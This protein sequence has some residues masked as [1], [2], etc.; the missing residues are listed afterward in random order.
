MGDLPTAT[1]G[2]TGLKV[3]RLGFGAMELR[4]VDGAGETTEV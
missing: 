2:G 1:L 4:D 3:S